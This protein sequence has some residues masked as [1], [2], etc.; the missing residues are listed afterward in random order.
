ML[1]VAKN[2]EALEKAATGD[3]TLKSKGIKRGNLRR[4]KKQNV[5]NKKP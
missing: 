2:V 3:E 4:K 1:P 5:P